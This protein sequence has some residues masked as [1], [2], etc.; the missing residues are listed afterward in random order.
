MEPMPHWR[1][2]RLADTETYQDDCCRRLQR[3]ST[4]LQDAW[5]ST[6]IAKERPANQCGDNDGEVTRNAWTTFSWLK[7]PRNE[8][9]CLFDKLLACR[10]SEGS[11]LTHHF[12]ISFVVNNDVGMSDI[13]GP[14]P[15]V[16]YYFFGIGFE[17]RHV[18]RIKA[19]LF[20]YI[21]EGCA[22]KSTHRVRLPSGR[23]VPRQLY[24]LCFAPN[25][26]GSGLLPRACNVFRVSTGLS[27][28]N[29]IHF[30]LCFKTHPFF[31]AT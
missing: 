1:D 29:W 30:E 11:T 7:T 28:P 23:T 3:L 31:F 5:L 22:T 25:E 17:V 20:Q 12:H 26:S 8:C 16:R 2:D 15:N 4:T 24:V 19:T 10:I 18:A 9:D 14:L 13:S 27:L 21:P 6:T